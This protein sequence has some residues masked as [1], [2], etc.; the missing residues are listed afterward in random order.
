[1]KLSDYLKQKNIML[2][3][4]GDYQD[5]ISEQSCKI[6]PTV[7]RGDVVPVRCV[8]LAMGRVLKWLL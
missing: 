5:Y 8:Y 3:K 6:R 1:M 4:Y 2:S 7:Y